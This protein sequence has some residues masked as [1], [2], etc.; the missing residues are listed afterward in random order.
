VR[1]A[2]ARGEYVE[3]LELAADNEHLTVTAKGG[4]QGTVL[5]DDPA[6]LALLR[7]YL[8]RRP[9][10]QPAVPRPRR[11]TPAGRCGAARLKN[12][13]HEP[14]TAPSGAVADL[15]CTVCG[16][17][18]LL[19]GDLAERTTGSRLTGRLHPWLRERGWQTAPS[20]RCPSHPDHSVA[21]REARNR[22]TR[23]QP[24]VLCDYYRRAD[25]AH[26][27]TRGEVN[28]VG[29]V[30]L[31]PLP[32]PEPAGPQRMKGH[33]AAS[34]EIERIAVRVVWHHVVLDCAQAD[35]RLYQVQNPAQALAG[36]CR[37]SREVRYS[38]DPEP[39]INAAEG[40]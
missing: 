36:V 33:R 9:Y 12:C 3:D 35:P 39:V 15:A 19:S 16:N 11:T 18:P 27:V 25:L 26:R 8:R 38:V 31:L 32:G 30:L 4:R 2:E 21:S 14:A 6:Q 29:R 40:G 34:E 13:A 7:W 10:P 28:V 24:V 23:H 20:L 5:L 17:G 37:P 22:P 1:A